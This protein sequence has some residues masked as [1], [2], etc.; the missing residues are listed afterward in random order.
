[1][2]RSTRWLPVHLGAADPGPTSPRSP[3][4]PAQPWMPCAAAPHRNG[5]SERRRQLPGLG[6]KSGAPLPIAGLAAQPL[7]G[8]PRQAERAFWLAERL[9]SVNA[10]A[11]QLGTSWPSLRQPSVATAWPSHPTRGGPPAHHPR[12]GRYPPRRTRLPPHQR[13]STPWRAP[14]SLPFHP[15][16]SA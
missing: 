16:A 1:M 14:A 15:K 12:L 11:Q 8:R 6:K 5:C 3:C 4:D 2:S 9:G 10:A 13:P 7:L